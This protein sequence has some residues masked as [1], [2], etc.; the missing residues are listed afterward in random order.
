MT[1]AATALALVGAVVWWRI[2]PEWR[3]HALAITGDIILRREPPC[4]T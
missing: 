4:P 1:T 2:G 3:T